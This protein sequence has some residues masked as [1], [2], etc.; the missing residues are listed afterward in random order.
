MAESDPKIK[1]PPQITGEPLPRCPG[2]SYRDLALADTNEVPEFLY[3][4]V[5]ENLGSDP[6]PASR[7]TDPAFF[8]L[9]KEKMWPNVWQFA[10]REEELPEPG[11]YMVYENVGKSFILMRQEDGSIKAFYNV[12]LHRGRKLK[13]DDGWT[14]ELQCPF[15]GFTWNNDGSL[16][17]IPCRWDFS[18][19]SDEK[20][21]LPE[22]S[23]GRWAG[24]IFIREAKEGPTIEEFLAPMPEHFKRWKHE[25][26]A[27]ALWVGKVIPANWKVVMEAFMESWHTVVT[28][29]QLLPFTGDAN[30]MYNI[31]GDHV[32]LTVTPFGTMSPH[33]DPE[34]KEQQWIV[35]EFVKYNGR[36]ADNYDA[37]E[38]GSA[39]AS[40]EGGFNVKV[41]AGVTARKALAQSMR[42]GYTKMYGHDHSQATDAELLDALVYNVFPNFAP[43]G[44]LMPNIVYRWRPW[45]DQ[46]KTLMEVRILTR[47]PK[48]TKAGRGVPMKFIPENRPWTDA[49]ELG[50]LADV[51]EQDMVNL[52]LVQEGLKASKTGLVQFGNYQEIR[53]RQFQQT[54]DKY[55]AREG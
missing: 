46:D 15:H 50:V 2:T 5:Y 52:P 13:L 44:G 31:Y 53:I 14:A 21:Q 9:E 30:S 17:N 54:L 19:L 34:G 43:W 28:H 27:T 47:V 36:S 22:V 20:M 40:E 3:Q 12:C 18:H 16:K 39:P 11:D 26:C 33:I 24:Y 29:P 23:V 37:G 7:Y 4:D 32:N 10:A 41:P 6:I 35:D 42:E 45:P 8:E 49:P 48:G 38:E 55:L 25:E 1:A 51:F